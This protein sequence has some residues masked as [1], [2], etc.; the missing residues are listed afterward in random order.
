MFLSAISLTRQQVSLDFL[1]EL[2]QIESRHAEAAIE[3][4]MH[5]APSDD[6]VAKLEQ[7]VAGN[8]RLTQ[9]LAA[10]RQGS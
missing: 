2:V 10:Q 9:E 8:A 7:M 1:L 3:A 5:S 6:T 4:I